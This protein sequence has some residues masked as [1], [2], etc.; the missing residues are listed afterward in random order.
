MV[1]IEDEFDDV[2]FG[3]FGE[4]A[5]KYVFE[6]E[7]EFE[8]LM[9]AIIADDLEGDFVFLLLAFGGIVSG[10]EAEADV[11]V[12]R[13]RYLSMH[14]DEVNVLVFISLHLHEF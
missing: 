7:E 3:H 9:V 8:G 6:V 14:A 4:L 11:L 12:Y 2:L 13:Y 10:G 5:G 1:S